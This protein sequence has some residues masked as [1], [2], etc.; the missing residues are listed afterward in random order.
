M[1]TTLLW[2]GHQG[3]AQD[4]SHDAALVNDIK[5]TEDLAKW[6]GRYTP[7]TAVDD[8][9]GIWLDVTGCQHLFGGEE[10][11]LEDLTTRL[12]DQGHKVRAA[13]ADTP[14]AAWAVARFD[15]PSAPFH[16]V[17][18]GAQR[19]IMASLPAAALRVGHIAAENLSRLGLRRIGDL[20]GIERAPLAKRFGDE[21]LKRLD[22]ALGIRDEPVSPIRPLPSRRVRM[23]FPD[24]I[25][26]SDDLWLAFERLLTALTER[27]EES[28]EGVTK[29]ELSGYRADGTLRSLVIG[30]GQASRDLEHLKR[31]MREKFDAFDPG[32]GVEAMIL[33]AIGSEPIKAIQSDLAGD[34]KAQENLTRLV[35]RLTNRL[36]DKQISVL[37][38]PES[39]VPERASTMRSYD[40]GE[41]TSVSPPPHDPITRPLHLLNAPEAVTAMAPVPDGPPVMFQWRRHSYRVTHA[42]GPERIAPE[43]WKEAPERLSSTHMRMRDYYRVEDEAGHRYWLFRAGAYQTNHAPKWY[44]HGVFA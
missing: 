37:E 7:W 16:I 2:R 20:Y 22:Q 27:L 8:T 32:Y 17:H 28:G 25:G 38:A 10:A 39:H 14:G 15:D 29:L 18:P 40:A 11:L 5:R 4:G 6:C 43:W 1:T 33:S 36:G 35:D 24:P 12:R 9:G 44:L 41:K 13:I 34:N 3:P 21:V 26:L 19:E 30:C 42:D 31:L 23:N